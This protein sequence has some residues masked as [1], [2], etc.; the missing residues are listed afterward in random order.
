MRSPNASCIP[1][2][3]RGRG[4]EDLSAVRWKPACE[5]AVLTQSYRDLSFVKR[6]GFFGSR[7]TSLTNPGRL[8]TVV[9][10]NAPT[11]AIRA[12]YLLLIWS[13]V[14]GAI[15]LRVDIIVMGHGLA[16][17]C[18]AGA[19]ALVLHRGDATWSGPKETKWLALL[20]AALSVVYLT[21]Q[22]PAGKYTAV[23]LLST[24]LLIWLAPKALLPNT[25]R[26][27]LATFLGVI[28]LKL[29]SGT[30]G[31]DFVA[32]HS[33]NY[34]FLFSLFF[35]MTHTCEVLWRGKN[36]SLVLLIAVA[37]I[38]IMTTG[39]ANI[40]VAVLLIAIGFLGIPRWRLPLAIV[41]GALVAI[42]VAS[43]SV[44]DAALQFH[45]AGPERSVQ[46]MVT[47]W[48]VP[49]KESMTTENVP[50]SP[51][52]LPIV[53]TREGQYPPSQSSL[54]F[55][56]LSRILGPGPV[57][58]E[59]DRTVEYNLQALGQTVNKPSS[60]ERFVIWGQYFRS[61]N[62]K[63]ALT[64]GLF[65]D[66]DQK[67]SLHNSYL[68]AHQKFGLPGLVLVGLCMV[69][70]FRLE[71]WRH[72]MGWVLLACCLRAGT[73]TIMFAGGY[74]DFGLIGLAVA[75]GA[76]ATGSRT[77]RPRSDGVRPIGALPVP[78]VR[79]E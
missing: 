77:A 75:T 41:C 67:V 71:L 26:F 70:F 64:G 57:S 33:R 40:G 60:D 29:A 11:A 44:R 62:L 55:G 63:T 73:D 61:L 50:P 6:R 7:S 14:A 65:R 22:Y 43:P 19:G 56:P 16:F 31:L 52:L 15:L 39:L 12:G 53:P 18:L 13:I 24:A 79:A 37:L 47:D 17:L 42:A 45:L 38:G 51:P 23:S 28:Y 68:G 25:S 54:P 4:L 27:A 20:L 59:T 72:I 8:A 66:V 58:T 46:A 36:P 78:P 76:A 69:L 35:F 5:E 9:V 2:E 21:T 3:R 74:F 48:L 49:H 1:L 32:L 34:V 10:E 30:P